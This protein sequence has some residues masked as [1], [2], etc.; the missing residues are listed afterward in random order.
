M[1]VVNLCITAKALCDE[2][3]VATGTEAE[4]SVSTFSSVEV[5]TEDECNQEST[6]VD[7]NCQFLSLPCDSMIPK[8]NSSTIPR[9]TLEKISSNY[10]LH[11][12]GKKVPT[13]FPQ[14]NG[15]SNVSVDKE[16]ILIGDEFAYCIAEDENGKITLVA[17]NEYT[18]TKDGEPNTATQAYAPGADNQSKVDKKKTRIIDSGD[19]S[20]SNPGRH[21]GTDSE[22]GKNSLTA[23]GMQ[24]LDQLADAFDDLN[25]KGEFPFGQCFKYSRFSIDNGCFERHRN[26]CFM[27]AISDIHIIMKQAI[28]GQYL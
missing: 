19:S 24:T 20:S 22:S 23:E 4:L 10:L 9:Y 11:V 15:I 1:S 8:N 28:K 27:I 26:K 7:T 3:D 6:D 25:T 2:S 18:N 14:L 5:I 17:F 12:T 13:P 16:Y 21:S